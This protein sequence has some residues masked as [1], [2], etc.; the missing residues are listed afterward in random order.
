MNIRKVFASFALD[1]GAYVRELEGR[2]ASAEEMLQHFKERTKAAERRAEALAGESAADQEERARCEI[3]LRKEIKSLRDALED[4]RESLA[5]TVERALARINSLEGDNARLRDEL[6]AA[7]AARLFLDGAEVG[8][9][10]DMQLELVPMEQATEPEPQVIF[11]GIVEKAYQIAHVCFVE[12]HKWFFRDGGSE[13]FHAPVL[14]EA[15]LARVA[16]REVAFSSG[17]AARL[18]M[19][20]VITRC[21]EKFKTRSEVVEVLEI[22]PPPPE[23][24]NLLTEARRAS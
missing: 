14:D 6:A 4:E 24:I 16:R 15:F 5:T 9:L 18:R 2:L 12:G 7:N 20:Q 3:S 23:Q 1:A 8:S 17:D 22:L 10:R 19:H 11:D 13:A 21:G